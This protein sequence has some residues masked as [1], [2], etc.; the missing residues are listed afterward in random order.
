MNS[1]FGRYWTVI[2]LVQKGKKLLFLIAGHSFAKNEL[3]RS[4]F[5]L[6]SV[7]NLLS[8]MVGGMGWILYSFNIVF[9]NDQ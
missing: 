5:L 7:A 2:G 1:M 8:C 4:T 6:K 3:E 9:S